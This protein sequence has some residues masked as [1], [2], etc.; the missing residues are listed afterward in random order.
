MLSNT[1]SSDS[2]NKTTLSSEIINDN[3]NNNGNN[4]ENE[5]NGFK[6]NEIIG[7]LF[8]SQD[9]LCHCVSEDLSMSK[10]IA[11][12]FKNK[13]KKVNELK[14]QNCKTGG[15]C[16][17]K[18]ENRFI[19]YLVTKQRYFYKPTYET[20]ENSLKCMKEHILQNNVK[21]LSMPLIGC[22]LDKLQW[23]NVKEILVKLFKDTDLEITVYKLDN[24]DS[25]NN[26]NKNNKQ[27]NN[28]NYNKRK[29]YKGNN[30]NKNEKQ[31]KK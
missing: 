4:N 26:N 12:L 25:N 22:G 3:N 28:N 5:K 7:D 19:Y 6:I 30:N 16:F 27:K 10:G 2:N 21:K 9:S 13:F 20:L 31:I 18:E 14:D 8:S 15:M 1:T 17:L 23:N 29:N 11:L 24:N